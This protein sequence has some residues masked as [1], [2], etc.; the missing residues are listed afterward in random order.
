MSPRR[1]IKSVTYNMYTKCREALQFHASQKTGPKENGKKKRSMLLHWRVHRS[2]PIALP[3]FVTKHTEVMWA[4]YWP[5]SI[6][7]LLFAYSHTHSRDLR[8]LG[9]RNDLVATILL[10]Q[11]LHGEKVHEC[12][13]ILSPRFFRKRRRVSSGEGGDSTPPNPTKTEGT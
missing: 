4:L 3:R 13:R 2:W 11:Y 5:S 6:W 10:V 1:K 8:S 9:R 7:R 12:V